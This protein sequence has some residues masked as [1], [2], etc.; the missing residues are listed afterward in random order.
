MIYFNS[1]NMDIRRKTIDIALDL[2][3]PKNIVIL[4]LKREIQKTQS[5]ELDKVIASYSVS[6]SHYFTSK[7]GEYR[8]ILIQAIHSCAVKVYICYLYG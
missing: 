3:S 5:K 2:V 6:I 7:A 8:Q 1:P 4:V